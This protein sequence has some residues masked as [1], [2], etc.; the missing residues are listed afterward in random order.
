[1]RS[2]AKHANAA[3]LSSVSSTVEL[4]AKIYSSLT[5]ATILEDPSIRDALDALSPILQPIQ[6]E[7]LSSR[8][9]YVRP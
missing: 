8:D 9:Q 3:F 5:T 1:M 6:C 4:Q 2:M 7:A